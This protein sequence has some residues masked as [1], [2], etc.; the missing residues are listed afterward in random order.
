MISHRTK[1]E[2]YPRINRKGRSQITGE[3]L[4]HFEGEMKS[5]FYNEITINDNRHLLH[6]NR[7]I[8]I[9]LRTG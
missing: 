3:K 4:H 8:D 9:H 7:I 6:N 5:L 2:Q 1:I